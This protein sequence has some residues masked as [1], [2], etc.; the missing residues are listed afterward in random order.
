MKGK[1]EPHFDND[2]KNSENEKKEQDDRREFVKSYSGPHVADLSKARPIKPFVLLADLSRKKLVRDYFLILVGSAIVAAGY[3]FFFAPYHIVPGGVYGITIVLNAVSKGW[4]DAFPDGLPM[5][6]MALFF[7][8][9]LWLAAY[10]MLGHHYGPKTVVTFLATALFT[11]LYSA[12]QGSNVL[13]KNDPL[14]AAIYGGA[15]L[16]VGVSLIFK[17]KGTSAG[18]DVLAKIVSRYAHNSVGV[19]IMIFDSCVVLLG[20][21]ALRSWEVPLYSWIAIFVYGKVVDAIMEGVRTEKAVLIITGRPMELRDA[22]LFGMHRGGTFLEGK[23]LYSGDE[24][25]IIY[26][27][28]PKNQIVMLKEVVNQVD[29]NAF[30]T[31]LPAYEILGKGFKSLQ[32]TV[33]ED[34][35]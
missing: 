6:T 17:A 18:T 35:E 27:V 1:E 32:K 22:I 24:K 16:G 3:S 29:P 34:K 20:L 33:A 26:T 10:R 13:I 9:P 28:V 25:H 8:I 30:L 23:G 4:F 11:D 7:N 31:V 12:L 19:N 5:G 21:V 14:L 15:I 2:S